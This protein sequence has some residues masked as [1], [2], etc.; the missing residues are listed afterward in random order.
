MGQLD[1]RSALVT[2]GGGGIG[3]AS[4]LALAAAGA[5]VVVADIA[6]E[7]GEETVA[8]VRAAGAP[9]CSRPSSSRTP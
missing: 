5:R 1:G 8:L 9:R 6:V 3:R 2:G 4:A 7:R